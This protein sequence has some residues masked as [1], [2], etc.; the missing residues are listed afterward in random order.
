MKRLLIIMALALVV[1]GAWAQDVMKKLDDG[2]YVVNTTTLTEDVKGYQGPT[3][4]EVHVKKDA[5][6]KV[7]PLKN[8]ETPKFF[9]RV[10]R[11]MLVKYEGLSVKKFA[12]TKVDGVTGATMS[13]NAI[14]ENVGRGVDYYM[15]NKKKV[16]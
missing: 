3:P 14:K 4:V 5:I 15:K 9:T 16:K 12:Q 10:K 13:S 11:E 7:V 8:M 1:S 2:T 6:V